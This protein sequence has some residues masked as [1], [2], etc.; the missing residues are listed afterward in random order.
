M[1]ILIIGAFVHLLIHPRLVGQPAKAPSQ[2]V[3]EAYFGKRVT[4]LYR[5]P[6][7]LKD[8]AVQEWMKAQPDYTHSVL[9]KIPGRQPLLSTGSSRF[10]D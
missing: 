8:P 4:D 6:E 5:N 2:P 3:T 9:D 7:D 1:K 10:P